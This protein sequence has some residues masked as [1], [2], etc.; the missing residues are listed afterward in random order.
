MGQSK[1]LHDNAAA[2]ALIQ[3]VARVFS[4]V[5]LLPS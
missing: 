3:H 2:A 1:K 4:G 5:G